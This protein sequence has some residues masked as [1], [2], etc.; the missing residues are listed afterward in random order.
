V[1]LTVPIRMCLVCGALTSESRCPA[2]SRDKGRN[3][4]TPGRGG[5]RTIYAF[6]NA[7]GARAGWRCEAIVSGVRCD[8]VDRRRLEAHHVIPLREGGTNDPRNGR[9]LCRTHHRALE[10]A[11]RG[12]H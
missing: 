2:H 12:A 1:G 7:V 8:V 10:N 11:I 9:L 6:R 3:R 5:A 4:Q